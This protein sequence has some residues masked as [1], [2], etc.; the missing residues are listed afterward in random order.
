M[1]GITAEEV[2]DTFMQGWISR[3]GVPCN[4]TTDQGRQFESDLFNRLLHHFAV[5]R[6]RTTS[7]HP[8]ANGMIERVHRQLKAALM[9]RS[10]SWL[11]SVPLV[12]LGM[13]STFK[14]D[15]KT[16][17]EEMLYGEPLRLPGEM[18]T[19]PP[20]TE[21][22]DDPADYGKQVVV[23]VDRIKPAYIDQD[24]TLPIAQQ[25][26]TPASP[27]AQNPV[28]TQPIIPPSDIVPLP[29]K[30]TVTTRSG[31]QVKFKDQIDYFY[32]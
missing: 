13:R 6:T 3:F 5:K 2:A 26:I 19:P 4:I 17:T 24:A 16:S 31:R 15:L 18:L 7:Y 11:S 25:T 9:C 28:P 32:F 22:S 10:D 12:L 29:D 27:S 8:C 14:E 20:G 30:Q 23:S 21:T 1:V